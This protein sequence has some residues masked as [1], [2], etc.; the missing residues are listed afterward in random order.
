MKHPT[1]NQRA[2]ARRKGITFSQLMKDLNRAA[3]G[4]PSRKGQQVLG[5]RPR[6]LAL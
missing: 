3:T 2:D 4:Q 1:S 6:D 5:F